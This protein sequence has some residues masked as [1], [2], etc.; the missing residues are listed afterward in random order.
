MQKELFYVAAS[1]GRKAL[2]IVTSDEELLRESLACSAARRSASELA[3]KAMPE[4]PRGIHRGLAAARSL[5]MRAAQ[6]VSLMLRRQTQQL[7]FKNEP[8]MEIDHDHGLSL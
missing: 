8:R 2:Q 7:T 1:R 3:R 5:A 6:Y 4:H